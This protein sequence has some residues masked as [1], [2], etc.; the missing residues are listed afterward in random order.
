M[1]EDTEIIISL[2][3]EEYEPVKLFEE[4]LGTTFK[5]DLERGN[6]FFME[7]HETDDPI[8]P[9]F[10]SV[11]WDLQSLGLGEYADIELAE[12][13]YQKK[14]INS[15]IPTYGLINNLDP[16]DHFWRLVHEKGKWYFG[17]TCHTILGGSTGKNPGVGIRKIA[18]LDL[19]KLFAG[20]YIRGVN[21]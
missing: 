10:I 7:A 18:K 3:L 1:F 9:S 4:V 12:K 2:K 11:F 21:I 6:V 20:K 16:Q 5:V 13:L 14:Q 17:D 15:I 8:Y 19:T